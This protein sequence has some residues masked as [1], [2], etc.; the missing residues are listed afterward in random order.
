MGCREI[1]ATIIHVI[2]I[3]HHFR[4]LPYLQTGLLPSADSLAR[5]SAYLCQTRPEEL[6]AL[7]YPYTPHANDMDVLSHGTMPST[8]TQDDV[9][10]IK[11][12]YE[13][14]RQIC[15]RARERQVAV[16]IDAEQSGYVLGIPV[17]RAQVIHRI[18]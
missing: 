1:G 7:P 16:I 2:H 9:T 3:Y 6:L 18:I 11:T 10:A 8:L 12:L 13:D 4:S 5:F 15:A 14:L 17:S